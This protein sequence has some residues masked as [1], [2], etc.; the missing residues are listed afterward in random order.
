MTNSTSYLRAV[1][2]VP[3]SGMDSVRLRGMTHVMRTKGSRFGAF[4]PPLGAAFGTDLQIV[5]D[6]PGVLPRGVPV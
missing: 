4:S 1:G 3:C 6:V 5:E 2:A